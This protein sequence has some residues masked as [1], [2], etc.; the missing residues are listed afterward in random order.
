M[1]KILFSLSFVLNLSFLGFGQVPFDCFTDT[2]NMTPNAPDNTSA[3]SNYLNYVPDSL[4]DYANTPIITVRVN[5]HL[6]RDENGGGIYAGDQSANV[7]QAMQWLNSRYANME[8]PVLPVSPP[9]EEIDDS[10][11]RFVNTGI[12]YHNSADL[13]NSNVINSSIYLDTYGINIENVV[14]VF[15][16]LNDSAPGARAFPMDYYDYNY[17]YMRGYSFS[18]AGVQLLA[19]ELGHIM[20]LIHTF[21]GCGDDIFDDT[22]YPDLNKGWRDCG[23]DEAYTKDYCPPYNFVGISNNIMG[24]NKCRT[25]FSPK[26]M[27]YM[28][29]NFI[30]KGHNRRYVSGESFAYNNN[31]VIQQNTVWETSKIITKDII[32]PDDKTLTIKCDMYFAND[33]KILV[34]KGGYLIVDGATLTSLDKNGFWK[35][36]EVQGQ[37]GQPGSLAYQG[38]V[39]LINDATIANAERAVQLYIRQDDGEP[40]ISSAGAILDAEHAHFVNNK[41]GVDAIFYSLPSASIINESS[42]SIDAEYYAKT[43]KQPIMC[44]LFECS[45]IGFRYT[46]FKNQFI[47]DIHFDYNKLPIGI[48]AYNSSMGFAKHNT[49][50]NLRYGMHFVDTHMSPEITEIR[51]NNFENNITGIYMS[52]VHAPQIYLNTFKVKP[53]NAAWEQMLKLSGIY[54]DGVIGHS[55]EENNFEGYRQEK[56]RTIGIVVN[57]GG[58]QDVEIYKNTFTEFNY[59]ILAQNSNR[60]ADGLHGLCFT[61]NEFTNN[62]SDMNVA[63]YSIIHNPTHGI[64]IN[65]GTPNMPAG[66]KFTPAAFNPL[67]WNIYNLNGRDKTINY[68][69]VQNANNSE[70]P[71]KTNNV[72]KVNCWTNVL[73]NPCA[74]RHPNTGGG[75]E[76][77]NRMAD[78]GVSA[79]T[80]QAELLTRIDEGNTNN[81]QTDVTTTTTDAAYQMRNRL[82]NLAPYTSETV[83]KEVVTQENT[84]NNALIRDVL[85]ANPQSAKSKTVMEAV[86]TKTQPMPDYMLEEIEAGKTII[87]TKEQK[88]ADLYQNT[89]NYTDALHDLLYLYS[90]DSTLVNAQDSILSTLQK[91]NNVY[92]Y[93][94]LA[95]MYLQMQAAANVQTTLS[96]IPNRFTLSQEQEAD[97]QALTAYYTWRVDLLNAGKNL[98]ALDESDI[99]QLQV[100]MEDECAI[101]ST[102]ALNALRATSAITY[103]E[104]YILPD[105]KGVPPAPSAPIELSTT[106]KKPASL[107]SNIKL[108]P[109]P[110]TDYV[111]LEYQLD[112][113]KLA[114]ACIRVIESGSGKLVWTRAISK[115]QD[116]LTIDLDILSAG[117]YEVQL[118]LDGQSV[119][120]SA[121]SISK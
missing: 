45:T 69:L 96:Q 91:S 73:P 80:I 35:G 25:Y 110:A 3:C 68:Y 26:Q 1:K 20:G 111:V 64:A 61:C 76:L 98:S 59:A 87:S 70:I 71:E 63:S 11:I 16:Y 81:L 51:D 83:L 117:H 37:K 53:F 54:L 100:W 49:F 38:M 39:S 75:N 109:N 94:L 52:D 93:Y 108:Y 114:N 4:N 13:Y 112:T 88:E 15:C 82:L 17:I 56:H 99:A 113:E 23:P 27:A 95:D 107:V 58:A 6:M 42:F 50:K 120:T 57:Q 85:V 2:D 103:E 5:F 101:L 48:K 77:K 28:H 72:R 97:Y 78:A 118:I 22:Y 46:V 41:I 106:D 8:A 34:Q 115:P 31:I 65:Q 121:L 74:S 33:A 119:H 84:I 86:E 44:K 32:I 102:K 66:N 89:T 29:H 21:A 79:Q 67:Q 30:T 7:A 92:D 19:H 36:I 47:N 18:W 40:I 10:R 43:N 90:T 55:V 116:A 9:A 14:N 105:D 104:P 60:S 24:Y 12:Y 62:E